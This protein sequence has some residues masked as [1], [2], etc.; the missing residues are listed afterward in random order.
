MMYESPDDI[1]MQNHL[2]F[3]R[4]CSAKIFPKDANLYY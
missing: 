2:I 3:D 1:V 4:I